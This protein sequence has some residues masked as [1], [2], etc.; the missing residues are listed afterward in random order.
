[1]NEFYKEF[2][3]YY[4]ENAEDYYYRNNL[5]TNYKRLRDI[6]KE[7][8]GGGYGSIVFYLASSDY[9]LTDEYYQIKKLQRD[10]RNELI[11]EK[12]KRKLKEFEFKRRIYKLKLAP[13]S[14][15]ITSVFWNRNFD[16]FVRYCS[17]NGYKY[18]ADLLDFDLR[19]L[20]GAKGFNHVV[21]NRIQEMIIQWCRDQL[22]KP[23]DNKTVV[24]DSGNKKRMVKEVLDEFFR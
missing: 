4:Y 8:S 2:L 1:M 21:I 10:I 6:I 20:Y 15:T 24:N 9:L 3:R 23:A 14:D 12:S 5:E 13:C 19:K 11:K 16:G 18:M 7:L 17:A 22:S